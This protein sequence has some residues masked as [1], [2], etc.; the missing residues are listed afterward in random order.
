MFRDSGT[1]SNNKILRASVRMSHIT[2]T[3]TQ[4]GFFKMYVTHHTISFTRIFQMY[5]THFNNLGFSEMY[6]THH[7]RIS[8]TRIFQMYVTHFLQQD[9]PKCMSHITQSH[10]LGFSKCMLHIFY[11]RNLQ[12]YVTQSHIRLT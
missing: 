4:P 3:I 9:F 1:L 11:M 12:M 8:N 10:P 5:V 7:Q 2:I 6:V